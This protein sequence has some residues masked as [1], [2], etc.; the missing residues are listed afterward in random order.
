MKRKTADNVSLHKIGEENLSSEFQS[1]QGDSVD[2]G[3][4]SSISNSKRKIN[5][6]YTESGSPFPFTDPKKEPFLPKGDSNVK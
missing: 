1:N 6:G 5:L 2:V 3:N 4:L